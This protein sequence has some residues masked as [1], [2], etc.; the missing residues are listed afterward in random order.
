MD[1]IIFGDNQFFGV[2]HISEQHAML[3]AKRFKDADSKYRLLAYVNEI[4]IKSFMFTTH[5]QMEPVLKRIASDPAF[6][7]FKLIPCMPYAHKYATAVTD[8]GILGALEKYTP[9]SKVIAGMKGLGS[10]IT[11][12][13]VPA[14]KLLVDS[15]MKLLGEHRVET[16]FLQ[17][18]VTD[19]LLGLGMG[20][21]F[22]E[23]SDHLEQKYGARAGFI[24]MNHSKLHEV[25]TEKVGIENPLICSVIN[26]IGFRM[27]PSQEL[28]EATLAKK[29]GTTIAMSI[30]ASGAVRPQAAVDY[31]SGIVGVDAV[32]FGA[33]TPEHILETQQLIKGIWEH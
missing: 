23:F 7:D 19:L 29:Q 11:H 22:G 12:N 2:N 21:M 10:L 4:G 3:Q 15:E 5:H 33:S 27:N 16:V 20:F 26:P 14:M 24:T 32:L 30:L 25:L 31:I 13:P 8:L 1:R 17:N 28:V 6:H 9:G 18:I